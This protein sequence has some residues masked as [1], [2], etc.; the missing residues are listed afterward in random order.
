[1]IHI[2]T[3]NWTTDKWIDIQL[4][5]FK[6]YIKSPYKVYTR[7][8]NMGEDLFNKHKN[9]YHHCVQG[10]KNEK[11]HVTVGMKLML[12]EIKKNIKKGDI[13]ML[14][15]S[16]AFFIKD[17]SPL[18]DKL[19]SHPFIAVQEPN[20]DYTFNNNSNNPH[21]MFYL[22][23]SEYI[24]NDTGLEKAL[25]NIILSPNSNWWG[26]VEKW[27]LD[28]KINYHPLHRSN[29]VNLHPLYFAIYN[30]MIYHHWAGSRHMITRPDRE[31]HRTTGE[32]L[33]SIAERNHK[34]SEEVYLQITTQL[35]VF[36]QFL[37]GEYNE[38]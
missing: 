36:I 30:N 11:F 4:P 14:I 7:L 26:G 12:S 20:H 1:M 24:S 18:L 8:G 3:I 9:K 37:K 29:S 6:K 23:K 25:T 33:E 28:N 17:I 21:P 2:I 35:D 13:I 27:L 32:S 10:N 5:S 15:D 22:F 38:E 16:D 19:Q 34:L 31:Q